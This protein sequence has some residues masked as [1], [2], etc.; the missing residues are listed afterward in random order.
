MYEVF[1]F[2]NVLSVYVTKIYT[3]FSTN[4]VLLIANQNMLILNFQLDPLK[5]FIFYEPNSCEV[6]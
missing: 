3:E 4:F 1:V 6:L 5:I 2:I